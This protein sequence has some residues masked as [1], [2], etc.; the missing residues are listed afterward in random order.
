LGKLPRPKSTLPTK[1]ELIEFIDNTPGRVG[2]REISRTFNVTAADRAE[3][4][5]ILSELQREGK[6]N[7]GRRR[8]H[9]R[10]NSLRKTDVLEITGLDEHGDL[11]AHP[12]HWTNFDSPPRV[13]IIE[14]LRKK[15]PL[16]VGDRILAKIE[17]SKGVYEARAIKLLL[18]KSNRILGIFESTDQGGIVRPSDKHLRGI[19][20]I[21]S[22]DTLNAL[23][24]E[25]VYAEPIGVKRYGAQGARILERLGRIREG[26]NLGLIAIHSYNIPSEFSQD[27]IAEIGLFPKPPISGRTNLA[28]LPLVTI[29]EDDARDFDDAIW[30]SQDHDPENGDGWHIIV[31]IADVSY[32]VRPDSLLDKIAFERGNSIYFP[33]SV[34]PMLPEKLSNDL[35]SLRPEQNR[36]CLAVSIWI[37][38]QGTILRHK[39]ERSM[40]RSRARLTYKQVQEGHD[41]DTRNLSS[42]FCESVIRPLYG[43]YQALNNARI[44][45]GVLDLDLPEQ[46]V[47]LGSDGMVKDIVRTPRYDSHR[48]IE[49]FMIAANIAAANS[50]QRLG[51]NSLFR[52]HPR[53][54]PERVENLREV[55]ASM[56][57]KLMPSGSLRPQNFN[58]ILEKTRGTEHEYLVN[59]LV[60]RSQSQAEYST[61]NAGHYGL[62]LKSYV[63][64]TSPIRRYADLV[65]HR[66]L[67]RGLSLGDDETHSEGNLEEIGK[68]I[69]MTE[70]RA[71][72]AERD[73]VGR[74]IAQYLNHQIGQVFAGRIN[75]VAKF[76]LFITL[77]NIGATGLLPTRYLPRD[78]YRLN[79]RATA[80]QGKRNNVRFTLGKKLTVQ[81]YKADPTQGTIILKL[82]HENFNLK[83]TDPSE[84]NKK[85]K[86]EHKR[87]KRRKNLNTAH[88][89]TKI[90]HNKRKVST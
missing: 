52:I 34:V 29:D 27:A 9:A 25:L 71:T 80:L 41:G 87:R 55:L 16:G 4:T 61:I 38:G 49:E 1:Q 73:T 24:N 21:A 47:K 48:V 72:V 54:D 40:M 35:C 31:A 11:F 43:A 26:H 56:D 3:L 75:G 20:I 76:G 51:M 19:Y 15:N 7:R 89:C 82:S 74:F 81:V 2:K 32:Y 33:D 69:S 57:I 58:A 64:F 86:Y 70:R 17:L 79:R 46:K 13:R 23:N 67:I 6:D 66:A 84:N 8:E 44:K 30:A 5:A 22:C 63:H 60:L 39:F 28:E 53:P 42:D 59:I 65:V 62:A 10:K 12:K 88:S 78:T 85:Q 45:R 68:H 14:N 90:R 83:A 18:P 37:D 36:P 77:D 50:I